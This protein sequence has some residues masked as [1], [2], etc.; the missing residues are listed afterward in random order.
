MWCAYRPKSTYT[1]LRA[2]RGSPV[3]HRR[4]IAG[5][6]RSPSR[7]FGQCVH[8]CSRHVRHELRPLEVSL[9]GLPWSGALAEKGWEVEVRETLPLAPQGL[10]CLEAGCFRAVH[11]VPPWVQRGGGCG[12]VEEGLQGGAGELFRGE[13]YPYGL[14]SRQGNIS[15]PSARPETAISS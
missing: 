9:D 11:V 13:G 10:A 7:I 2:R 1:N 14:D 12:A 3:Q 4:E 6:L 15:D 5:T 8:H